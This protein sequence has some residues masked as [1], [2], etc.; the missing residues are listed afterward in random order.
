MRQYM[1]TPLFEPSVTMKAAI[2]TGSCPANDRID[3]RLLA[4]SALFGVGWGIA[5]VCPGP[6]L[7][8]LA[9]GNGLM[10]YIVPAVLG[11]MLMYE[12]SSSNRLVSSLILPQHLQTVK[13]Y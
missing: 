11:G 10:G 8:G 13:Q 5:G 2:P 7:V 12:V 9:A 1:S 6:A 4:G 3:W